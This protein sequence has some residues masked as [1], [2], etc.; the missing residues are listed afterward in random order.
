MKKKRRRERENKNCPET[1][2]RSSPLDRLDKFEGTHLNKVS[3]PGLGATQVYLSQKKKKINSNLGHV[4]RS[5]PLLSVL[6]GTSAE[7]ENQ[8]ECD[9]NY[10]KLRVRYYYCNAFSTQR[11]LECLST[12]HNRVICCPGC[13]KMQTHT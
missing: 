1:D 8:N 12:N 4:K 9:I 11:Q 13:E 2:M 10:T 7:K 5:V 6:S 3:E